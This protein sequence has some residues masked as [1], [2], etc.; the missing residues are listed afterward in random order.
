MAD[1]WDRM[2]EPCP[3]APGTRIELVSMSNDP[4]PVAFGT[5]GTVTGGNGRQIW[6]EWDNGR[7]LMLL[8]GV[9]RW[10]VIP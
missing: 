5:R 7:S 2:R 4:D 9:D 8:P 10:K 3:L 1:F 6:V